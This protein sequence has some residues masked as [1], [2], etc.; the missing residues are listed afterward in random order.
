MVN[1]VNS[2]RLSLERFYST[3]TISSES[4][5]GRHRIHTHWTLRVLASQN[6]SSTFAPSW[7][8]ANQFVRSQEVGSEAEQSE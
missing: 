3:F 7:I 1:V 2:L 4:Q 6:G 5:R 8:Y